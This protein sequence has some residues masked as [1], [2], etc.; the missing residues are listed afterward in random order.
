MLESNRFLL[1]LVTGKLKMCPQTLSS[2]ED[3]WTVGAGHP[4]RVNVVGLDVR[5]NVALRL[6]RLP[7]HPAHPAQHRVLVHALRNFRVQI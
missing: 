5:L 3:L 1:N 6:R 2:F 4:G 7:A